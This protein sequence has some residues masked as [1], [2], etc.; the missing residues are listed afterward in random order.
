M[1]VFHVFMD[2]RNIAII[3]HVDH[4]K[5]TLVDGML[6]QTHTFRENE[7]EMTQTT[8]LDRNELE[9]EKGITIFAKNIAV[10]YKKTKINIIDTPGHA[11][12]S[13]EV[14]RVI[15][16]AD[17]ALL[18]VDAAEGPL[19]Q[20][21]F[22]L[23]QALK[24]NLKLIVVVNK[25]DRKDARP[26]EVLHEIEE[27]FLHLAHHDDHLTFPVLYAIGREE[28]T[29]KVMP[30]DIR[31]KAD[32]SPL[33]EEIIKTIPPPVADV[34]KPFKML[35]STLDFDTHKGSFAIGKVTQGTVKQGQKVLQL[36]EKEV[37]G[38]FTIQN[39]FS[40]KG[41]FRE[42]I[43]ESLPGD[44]IAITGIP[45][46]A[47]GQTIADPED[48]VG[49]PAMK[50]GEPTLKVLIS[51]N[52]SPLSGREGKF[53]TARQIE[54][55]LIK[56]KKTNIGLKIETN[57]Q[58]NGFIVSGRGELH[59]AI[60]IENLRREGYELQVGR[61]QV[62]LKDK[63]GKTQE[64]IEEITIEIDKAYIGIIVEELG[65]RMG[66]LIDTQTNEQ[67]MTRM[68]YRISSR[69][70][71]GLRSSILTK[72]RGNGLFASRFLDYF[73][74]M[75]LIDKQRNGVLIAFESGISTNFA[76]ETVQERGTSFIGPGVS[77]YEGMIIGLNKR[78]EDME[79]NVC[80]GKKM[81]NV[82]SNA[83]IAVKLD[84][85]VILTLE[86]SLDFIENDELLEVTPK[87][88]RLRKQFL[89]KIERNR[90]RKI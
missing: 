25:I 65:K 48:P 78:D 23:S 34:Q 5:T 55:R 19:P 46:V 39:V 63:N 82:R 74:E 30:H 49:Y 9:R 68:V 3:A 69:N 56:E 15:N 41:L 54:Q 60:L 33:F 14:E 81:T 13:G 51:P 47:I 87:S 64:P 84:P 75:P 89:S 28:K 2:I 43:T 53:C 17:G 40:S 37:V 21:Q 77:V 26:K 11:D 80:K 20:T 35:V 27:L 4:G 90:A 12:F 62:I 10:I 59:L 6:K 1:R 70:L 31:E 67:G 38:N 45:D 83:D 32:L 58:G 66:E 36:N 85:P 79:I 22:V 61:P 8:I 24:Q 86:Q 42:E 7:A 73:D 50:V 52:T 29:W 71:L 88:L 18:I 44:I 16:M 76:L 72:T 57:P